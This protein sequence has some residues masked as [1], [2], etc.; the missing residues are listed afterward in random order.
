[1]HERIVFT[2]ADGMIGREMQEVM[3]NAIFLGHGELE[4]TDRDQGSEGVL[5]LN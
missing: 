3:P 2:G 1:M 4:I 5:C